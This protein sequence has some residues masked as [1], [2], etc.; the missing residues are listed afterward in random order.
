MKTGYYQKDLEELGFKRTMIQ[1]WVERGFISPSIQKASG[2]GTNQIWSR[3]D[4]GKLFALEAM[5]KAG[6][7]RRLA[8]EILHTVQP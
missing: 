4:V 6:F 5:V 8:S 2:H 7:S 1:Q 3:E